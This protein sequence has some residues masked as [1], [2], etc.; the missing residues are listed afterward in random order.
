MRKAIAIVA[1]IVAVVPAVAATTTW[2]ANFR[3]VN[4]TPTPTKNGVDI[5]LLFGCPV[6]GQTQAKVE[7]GDFLD[8]FCE[9]GNEPARL[10]YTVQWVYTNIRGE[11]DVKT[12]TGFA[13]HSCEQDQIARVTITGVGSTH[14]T[15]AVALSTECVDD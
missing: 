12:H 9:V 6:G 13:A 10:A 5:N 1:A 15:P 14:V 8:V 2:T 3:A 4:S 11:Q 7:R